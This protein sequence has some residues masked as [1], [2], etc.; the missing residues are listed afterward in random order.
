MEIKYC[1]DTGLLFV[2]EVPFTKERLEKVN[3]LIGYDRKNRNRFKYNITV[4]DYVSNSDVTI[5]RTILKEILLVLR[6]VKKYLNADGLVS[7]K[8]YK[9]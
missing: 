1:N 7:D 8:N 5:N 4:I 6:G 3:F 2:N 9:C